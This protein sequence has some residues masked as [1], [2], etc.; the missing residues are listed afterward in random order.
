MTKSEQAP[1]GSTSPVQQGPAERADA[2]Q[3]D[4]DR[5]RTASAVVADRRVLAPGTYLVAIDTPVRTYLDYVHVGARRGWD[6][7]TDGWPLLATWEGVHSAVGVRLLPFTPGQ[8]VSRSDIETLLPAT[9]RARRSVCIVDA[10]FGALPSPRDSTMAIQRALDA[11]RSMATPEQP[12]DVIVPTGSF[13]YSDILD[14]GA[15]V[16]LRGEG[17][18]L[19]ATRADA[20]AIHLMGDRSGALFLTIRSQA[21]SRESSVRH[22]GIW[23][24][25]SRASGAPVRNVWVV[26]NEVIQTKSA[27]FVGIAEQGGVWAFNYAHDGFA[28]AF[29]HTG[30]SSGCQVIANRASGVPGRGDDLYAFVGYEEDGDPVHHCS[31]I[32]NWGRNGNARGLSA[33]GAGFLTFQD[34]D[35]TRTQAAGIYIARERSYRTY[36]SFD[37]TVLRNTIR[38][39]NQANSHDGLLAYSDA[40]LASAPSRSFGLIPSAVRNLTIR[41]NTFAN[42]SAG[43]SHGFGIEVRDSCINGIVSGNTV[44]GSAAPGIVVKGIGFMNSSNLWTLR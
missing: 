37:V 2:G 8:V 24:G 17:G 27:H 36:G 26:G 19:N 21:N 42:T 16:R 18:V 29:H 12:V 25:P 35:I 44:T 4:V 41:D 9:A 32:A 5:N 34:N 31:C 20:S 10:P 38:E 43:F 28:D 15:D 11:A 23:V 22:S 13:N 40:P 1:P 6:P 39:A 3:S 33:V 7:A 30:G 14:V